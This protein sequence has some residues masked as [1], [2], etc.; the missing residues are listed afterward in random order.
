MEKLYKYIIE[1]TTLGKIDKDAAIDLVTMLKQGGVKT[2][3]NIAIIGMS[4]KLP[5]ADNINEFWDNVKNGI[6]CMGKF[7]Q[8]RQTDIEGYLYDKNHDIQEIKYCDGAYLNRIDGFDYKFFKVSP[9][10]AELMDPNQRLFLETAWHAIED[11]GYGGKRLAG[12]KAGVFVGFANNIRDAYGRM[13]YDYQCS[14]ATSIVGNLSAILPSRIAFLLDLKGPSMV[15]D[16]ACSSSLVSVAIAC[17]SI[18]SG[19]C[20]MAIA[21]GVKINL[22]PMDNENEKLGM[23]SSD[24]KTRA[25]DDKA[26]GAGAGEGVAVVVLKPLDRALKDG[27]NIYAVIKGSSINQDG[28]SIGITAPNPAAQS[29]LI[30]KVWE[31][32]KIDPHTIAYIEAHGTGT[33][34]GDPIE[35][36]GLQTAFRRYTDNSQFCAIG[37]VKSNIGHLYE[38]AGV[39]SLVKAVM[40]LKHRQLPPTLYFDR[41]NRTIDFEQSPIYVNT[42]PRYWNTGNAPRRCGVSAFGIS[43][44]NCHVVLEEAPTSIAEKYADTS[45]NIFTLSAKSEKSFNAL[46]KEYKEILE[47]ESN[48]ELKDICCTANTGRGHYNY[49]IAFLAKNKADLKKKLNDFCKVDGENSREEGVYFGSHRIIPENKEPREDGELSEKQRDSLTKQADSVI[50]EFVSTGRVDEEL[51]IEICKLYISGAE[52]DWEAFY[53]GEKFKKVSLPV[54]PFEQERC[55]LD[56]PRQSEKY[57]EAFQGDIYYTVGWLKEDSRAEDAANNTG[58]T[59]FFRNEN[60]TA[61]TLIKKLQGNNIRVIDVKLGKTYKKFNECKYEVRGTKEDYSRLLLESS[62]ENLSHII[63]MSATSDNYEVV[64]LSQLKESLETGVFSFFSLTQALLELEG[65]EN[66]NITLISSYVNE[67]TGSEERISPES[68]PLFG[69]GKV[70]SQ[71]YP[72]ISCR[73]ID[74]DN[75]TTV[76]DIYNELYVKGKSYQIA[77]RMGH[78]YVEQFKEVNLEDFENRKITIKEDGVYIITGGTRG[79][80][81]EFGK[82]LASKNKVKLALIGRSSIPEKEMWK[83]ILSAGEDERLCRKLRGLLEIEEMGSEVLLYSIDVSELDAVKRVVEN[84]RQRFGKIDGVIHSAGVPGGGFI[85]NKDRKDFNK[86]MNPKIFG[87][88]N[89]DRSTREDNLDFF[90]MF[91]SGISIIG[92]A[93]QGDYVAAN[94]YLDSYTAYR[95]KAGSKTLTVNWVSW[96]DTGM[97]VD[98]GINVD[99]TFKTI[100]TEK[101]LTAFEKVLDK[102]IKR[103][104]IGEMNVNSEYIC[105]VEHLPFRFSAKVTKLIEQSKEYIAKKSGTMN[106]ESVARHSGEVTL[107]GKASEEYS[108]IEKK[109]AQ[110]Y[111]EILGFKEINIYESFFELGGDSMLINRLHI[112]LEAEFPGKVK[113]TD[114]F[115]NATISKL[116]QFIAGKENTSDKLSRK[117]AA[118]EKIQD[119]DKDI[120]IIG[121]AA[122][123]PMVDSIE[124]FWENIK[125]GTDF[126]RK[127]PEARKKEMDNYLHFSNMAG[128]SIKYYNGAYLEDI[129]DFDYKFFRL[130]PKEASLTDPSQR[131]FLKTAWHVIEDA[132]YGGGKLRG[133]NTAV[134]LGY[135]GNIKDSYQKIIFEVDPDAISASAVGNITAMMPTRISYLLDLK[136]P[137]MVVDTACSSTLVAT[138][139]ACN[140]I[141]NGE[142]D[143]A[144]AGGVRIVLLPLDRDYMRIGI[145]STSGVT[146]TF[147]EEADGSGFGEGSVALLLKPLSKAMEDRDNIYAVIKGSAVNQD[148]ASMGITAPNPDSQTDVILKAWEKAGL[149]PTTLSF[150]EA[151]G[152]ATKLGDPIEIEGITKAFERYTDKMQF[153]PISTVKSNVG[154]LFEGAGIAAMLKAIMALKHREIPPTAN[155]IRPNRKI[156]FK[157]SPV[158]VNTRT[159]KWKFSEE[160]MRCAISSFGFSGTNCHMVLEEAPYIAQGEGLTGINVFTLSAKSKGA[161]NDLIHSYHDFIVDKVTDSDFES[162]CYTANTGRGHY[163]YR[164]AFIAD[165][166]DS[167]RK[168]LASVYY[169]NPD[170]WDE[171]VCFYGMHTIV[172]DSKAYRDNGE[173]S[174]LNKNELTGKAT[175]KINEFKSSGLCNSDNLQEIC[176]LYAAGA[177]INWEELYPGRPINKISIPLYTFEQ[178]KCWIDIPDIEEKTE[179]RQ[180]S[181]LYFELG[182]QEESILVHPKKEVTGTVVVLKDET[183]MGAELSNRLRHQ[184]CNVIEVENGTQYEKLDENNFTI[185]GTEDDYKALFESVKEM[186]LTHI[187]HMLTLKRRSEIES[188]GELNDCVRAGTHSLFYLTRAFLKSGIRESIDILLVTDYANAITCQEEYIKPEN[189]PLLGLGKVVG[190]EYQQITCRGIDIDKNTTVEDILSELKVSRRTYLS[191]Y[192]TGK[193]YIEEFRNIDIQHYE[194]KKIEIKN[195][196]V[197]VITGGTGG[198]GLEIAKY[199]SLKKKVNIALINRSKMPDRKEWASVL[200]EGTDLKLAKKIKSILEIEL[201]GS[202]VKCL[203][204]DICNEQQIN[205]VLEK[206]RSEYGRING[207]VHSAGVAGAGYILMK[208]EKVFNSVLYPKIQGTWIM[209]RVTSGD[210]LDFFV[211]FS[212]GV[213]VTGEAGQGDYVAANSYLDSYAAFRSRENK[214]TLT[215]NWVQWKEAGMSVEFGINVDGIFKATPTEQAMEGFETALNRDVSRVLIGEINC[216]S[217][218]LSI[219]DVLPFK[220]SNELMSIA[221]TK[222]RETASQVITN[223]NFEI[224][225]VNDGKVTLLPRGKKTLKER[226]VSVEN[227]RLK[228][229][230]NDQ[231]NEIEQKVAQIYSLILGFKEIGVY[232][233][234][235]ELGGDSIMLSRMHSLLEKEFPGKVKLAD[236]FAYTSVVRLAQFIAT[237]NESIPGAGI[238]EEHN[239]L[240]ADCHDIA[241]IGVSSKLPGAGNLEE[242]WQN[243]VCGVD[244]IKAFPES[245]KK[246]IDKYLVYSGNETEENLRY[247]E[248]AYIEDIDK[249]DYRF[250]RLSPKEASLMDP[251]QR[252]FLQTVWHAIEDAG[253]GGRKLA[254]TRTG[255]YIGYASTAKDSYHKMI[256]ETEPSSLPMS[257]AG[258]ITAILPSRISYLLDLKGPTMIIDTACSASLVSMHLACQALRLGECDMAIAGG[259]RINLI[260]LDNEF[261]RVGV[262]SSTGRTKTFDESADGAGMGEGVITILLKPLKKAVQDRDN[263]Y[264]VIKG[265]AINQDGASIGLTAPNPESQEDVLVRA[266]QNARVSPETLS[267]IEVHG[268]ATKLGDP[269]EIDGLNRAFL[270]YTNKKQFCAVSAVK[271]NIGHLFESSGLAGLLKGIMAMQHR[272]LP[273]SIH[274]NRPNS[275]VD[276]SD[277]PIYV[278]T[279]LRKWESDNQPRRLGISSFGLGGTNCHVVVEEPPEPDQ[280]QGDKAEGPDILTFSAVSESSLYELVRTYKEFLNGKETLNIGDICY[281]ANTGRG[282]YNYRLTIIAES[283]NDLKVQINKLNDLKFTEDNLPWFFYGFHKVVNENAAVRNDTDITEKEKAGISRQTDVKIEEIILKESAGRNELEEICKLYARGADVPWEKLYSG[284][285]PKKLSIPVYPFESIR[286]WIDIPDTVEISAENTDS[287]LYYGMKWKEESG[288][289]QAINRNRA[290][291]LIFKDHT[292]MA[293][294]LVVRLRESG[295]EVIEVELGQEFAEI[296][297]NSYIIGNDEESYKKLISGIQDRVPEQIIHLF[298]LDGTEK[299]SDV[300]ELDCCMKTGVYSM[301]YLARALAGNQIKREIDIVLI[302]GFVNQVTGNDK[303]IIPENAP[304]FG[305]GKVIRKE[306]PNLIC[307]C[308]DIDE[309]TKMDSIMAELNSQNDSYLV[310]FRNGH[311]YIEE[312]GEIDIQNTADRIISIKDEGVY[313][314]TGGAGGIGLEVSKYLASKNN[315]KLALINRSSLPEHNCWDAV[316][317]SGKDKKLCEKIKGIINLE[318]MGAEVGYYNADISNVEEMQETLDSIKARFGK[319]NGIIHGAGVSASD[320]LINRNP[321]KFEEVLAPKVKGTWILDKL[322]ESDDMDF[323]IMFSSIATIFSAP[324]QDCYVAA[325]S[326]LDTFSAYRNINGRRTLTVNWST[327]KET[328][329]AANSGFNIDTLFKTMMTERAIGGLDTVLNK[330]IQRVLIG[331]INYESKI[332][333]LMNRSLFKLSDKI[334]KE[335]DKRID[336]LKFKDRKV[337]DKSGGKVRLMGKID[338]DYKETE[339]I[340]A[341]ICRDI[342]GFDEINIHDSFFELGADSIILTSIHSEVEKKFPGKVAITD[343]FEYSTIARLSQYITEQADEASLLE[344]AAYKEPDADLDNIIDEMEKGNISLDEVLKNISRM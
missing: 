208:D 300:S 336:K 6:D 230:E 9:R 59:I 10:E 270:R 78:R 216:E 173:I 327:W 152:T 315:I 223:G 4:A 321:D 50:E 108:E 53:K 143:M 272:E 335:L 276:F 46:L 23:E 252:V 215:I 49:R 135:A 212:S 94:S 283:F 102:N 219:A 302:S 147:D 13:V 151:H 231:Y 284:K 58:T 66:L 174:E 24:S 191:A 253:Y 224:A 86:V 18:K 326:Y 313:I 278:N 161:F 153:C 176:R 45:R 260:P 138:H 97:S 320:L 101:A 266:W 254:G 26:E 237:Q 203:D 308:I 311:R 290:T 19:L 325:N 132:G 38:A 129:A 141:R 227:I 338:G 323:F 247:L 133:S 293:E 42:K 104:I 43:G 248:G 12:T 163:N 87:T 295:Q 304:L 118:G 265:S 262:E 91:S 184:G 125:S 146:R 117:N 41:P 120:A 44:T 264:A 258:N 183:G 25:F 122:E 172:P 204:A 85:I 37:S 310:A 193:R 60:E 140:A 56:V 57:Q 164:M 84:L 154:H 168:K 82:F 257:M 344:A 68:A 106:R 11:S 334:E 123:M 337:S 274:F 72:H 48:Y 341:Q 148:G 340:L 207:V 319:I 16:T 113:V 269:I 306:H 282:H 166:L 198:I 70:I 158:Y 7:P 98:F 194:Q 222:N 17:Q 150:I 111:N 96:K 73:C 75:I 134:F 89:L 79:I 305:I 261:I 312:F 114:L 52:I 213:S 228:G 243:I 64:E 275:R 251:Y 1:N 333:Y 136:G 121:M 119:G 65:Q 281:T 309:V 242:Y 2:D 201:N 221:Q 238:Q 34:L 343:I 298:T 77:Y 144:I 240:T 259:I 116:A 169:S 165:D 186:G 131:L 139:L 244:C 226:E 209:D 195:E 126:V 54:Y 187:V 182:W 324:G 267:Y 51:L 225:M 316:L 63:Y 288:I 30:S 291:T 185:A 74:I 241:I 239:Y 235:F 80:G 167:L 31:D 32:S 332:I 210:E 205:K 71:E 3:D 170:Q 128:D 33:N 175:E 285:N 61:Q 112:R 92:E 76:Q 99:L 250:F 299:V 62:K 137:T 95:N 160:P 218:F 157:S 249:F 286:C 155:F 109:V 256:Y 217:E 40:A 55:W 245:R 35:I 330:D 124:E 178:E 294:I 39:V 301:F 342:L 159:R 280:V 179:I 199:F 277:T 263:I 149:D 180:K 156:D 14:E 297:T 196:G 229:K 162:L 107:K 197:Y 47:N 202:T 317:E 115:S 110:I 214:R 127:F 105:Q 22:F 220:L 145:E 292:G 289:Q 255:V 296:N 232:D 188:L 29:D 328:G 331:D 93:G 142:C 322:T 171:K 234:F 303:R 268:T 189:A 36:K 318:S 130:S 21:G 5:M 192:R 206:L 69:L 233:S 81:L 28:N 88:W 271:T 307:R 200:E 273:P 177:D 329:M 181:G 15:I 339:K 100:P 67:V 8:Q 236:L 190:Q 211:L 287:H 90:V 27:D 103:T 246:D 279:R 83:E 314:V 20:D